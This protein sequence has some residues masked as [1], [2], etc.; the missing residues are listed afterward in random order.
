[1]GD[2]ERHKMKLRTVCIGCVIAAGVA[3]AAV[4]ALP[5]PS[6]A[7]PPFLKAFK[8]AY[9]AK[10]D[11]ESELAKANC[12]VCH[13]VDKNEKGK[14][15]SWNKFGDAVHEIMESKGKFSKEV[16]EEALK[17]PS[18]EKDKSFGDLVKDKKLPAK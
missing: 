12:I 11:K 1:M 2:E 7:K 17:K 5:T 18:A 13:T 10:D 14:M 3:A 8:E 16:L 4:L 9:V 6:Q 15:K